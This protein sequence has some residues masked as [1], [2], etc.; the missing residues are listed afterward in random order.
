MYSPLMAFLPIIIPV[1]VATAVLGQN[2][3]VGCQGAEHDA[4]LQAIKH[5]NATNSYPGGPLPTVNS[6][7]PNGIW[8][9]NI[10]VTVNNTGGISQRL[11][12]DTP[13]LK[14][15]KYSQVPFSVFAVALPGLSRSTYIKAQGDIGDCGATLSPECASAIR[16]VGAVG[17][18]SSIQQWSDIGSQLDAKIALPE[19]APF[20]FDRTPVS[21]L[22]PRD[23]DNN[24]PKNYE[25]DGGDNDTLQP[26][27]SL[28]E[29]QQT[30][31]KTKFNET[32]YDEAVYQVVPFLSIIFSAGQ[33]ADGSRFSSSETQLVCMRAKYVQAGSRT[34]PAPVNSTTP[35][36]PEATPT[37]PKATPTSAAVR[38]QDQ[39][40]CGAFG[41]IVLG[42]VMF[43]S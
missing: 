23:K 20:T 18:G 9:Y 22:W 31:D 14:G 37:A 42:A 21:I 3:V 33:H 34:P 11:W 5:L 4:F 27:F 26:L 40:F 7:I 41:L 12:I 1:L 29:D 2:P 36:A 28:N 32:Q 25:C 30:A 24:P 16:D 8:S 13:N 39:A 15:V 10:G 43:L 6:T 17:Q 35:T 38:R 19:C